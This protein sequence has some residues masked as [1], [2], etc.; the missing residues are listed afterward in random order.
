[1][2][3]INIGYKIVLAFLGV[4]IVFGVV[5]Y[6]GII[7]I[8]NIT[9][10]DNL[11]YENNTLGITYSAAAALA[12]DE[13]RFSVLQLS[14]PTTDAKKIEIVEKIKRNM[15]AVDQSLAQYERT[16]TTNDNLDLY[17]S[18]QEPWKVFKSMGENTIEKIE[19]NLSGTYSNQNL[20]YYARNLVL[21]SSKYLTDTMQTLFT[22]LFELNKVM[23]G[24]VNK[25]NKS[26]SESAITYMVMLVCTGVGIA[27]TLGILIGSTI[28]RTVK[29]ASAQLKLIAAGKDTD[30][31]ELEKFSGEFI[32][33][34]RDLNA[35]RFS[36]QLLLNDADKLAH[37]G[38]E[39]RLSTRADATKHSGNYRA[40]IEGFN[41]SL[42][43]FIAPITETV[44]VL[45]E[46]R[47]GDL[48]T[49]I[50]GEYPG[51]HAIIKD[52]LNDTITTI[53][54]YINE[55]S[56]ILKHV[57]EGN[58]TCEI[59]SEYRGDFVLLKDSINSIIT[60]FNTLLA[61]IRLTA[62][63]VASGTIQVS[64]NSQTIAS[65]ATEQASAIEQLTA[66]T[67]QIAAQAR[68]NAED[69]MRTSTLSIEVKKSAENGNSKMALMQ[70]SMDVM[71]S[72]SKNISNIIQVIDDIA[73]QTNILALNAAV[74]AARAG[75]H[76]KGF[77]VVAGEVRALAGRS[78]KAV[79]E[80]TTL[81]ESSVKSVKAGTAIANE[82]ADALRK[83][84]VGAEN[85]VTLVGG[86][87]SASN[88]QAMAVMQINN[89]IGHLS[90]IV[91][92][93]SISAQEMAAA[94]QELS[95][96]AQMLQQT[97]IRFNL[98]DNAQSA[99]NSV[100][101]SE[102]AISEAG[103]NAMQEQILPNRTI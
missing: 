52:A 49:A 31:L 53:S 30:E 37:A 93:N 1:M 101:S 56:N 59:S 72:S 67:T 43:A 8:N 87:A 51:D 64:D 94:A 42:D 35:V 20:E 34:A 63:Q 58:L 45:K 61:D 75:M 6:I 79:E 103:L 102:S 76:G 39:G 81:I 90:Q 16:I 89:G 78:A 10:N 50:T 5:G 91:Q 44:D 98:M 68:Q 60:S 70:E 95:S 96:Q 41:K 48:R 82:T 29:C 3:K 62:N 2:R 19:F 80:T 33:I 65:G 77:E 18:L 14:A 86:I 92:S 32:N 57:A 22:A 23:A 7:N 73:F 27:I 12:F 17:T 9:Y 88:Q 69:A 46:L 21:T 28:A 71:R 13:L 40:I 55:I 74:E 83:I 36:L 24:T 66:S 47:K 100:E 54:S 4:A 97:V 11:L 85:A 15:N 25:L 99:S 84:V 26:H 38:I